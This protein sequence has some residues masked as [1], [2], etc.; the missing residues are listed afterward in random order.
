[1]VPKL[2]DINEHYVSASLSHALIPGSL[3]TTSHRLQ[4]AI[5]SWRLPRCFFIRTAVKW[6]R[7]EVCS[8]TP[9]RFEWLQ[10]T[11]HYQYCEEKIRETTSWYSRL[12]RIDSKE[13]VTCPCLHLIT[14]HMSSGPHSLLL[15][16]EHS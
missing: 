10:P 3:I 16:M 8:D 2:A 1:V 6:G 4:I 12:K 11:F 14:I 15:T 9:E 7:E 13:Y 5:E